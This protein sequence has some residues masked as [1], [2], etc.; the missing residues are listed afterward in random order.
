[1]DKRLEELSKKFGL[2]LTRKASPTSTA[3]TNSLPS[4]L[5][6]APTFPTFTALATVAEKPHAG[7][8]RQDGL[9]L[10]MLKDPHI[11]LQD[12]LALPSKYEEEVSPLLQDLA[13]GRRKTDDLS[14]S[15]LELLDRATI[16]YT[17]TAHTQKV[18]TAP[19][20]G[21]KTRPARP[22]Y[23]KPKIPELNGMEPYWWLG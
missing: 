18:V 17:R 11:L 2:P 22:R 15:E 21:N 3:P 20:P 12:L 5:L 14:G 4:V 1:M 8:Q 10:G 23:P 13:A 7:G 9:F 6:L 16:D 19:V